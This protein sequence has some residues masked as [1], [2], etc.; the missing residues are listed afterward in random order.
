M[1]ICMG[2]FS[3]WL[4]H[5]DQ[6]ELF[7]YLY[8]NV[9]NV[10]FLALTALLLWPLGRAM[11]ALH[12]AKGY[13]LFWVVLHVAAAVPVLSRR[14]FRVDMGSHSGAH[15]IPGLAVSVFLQAGWSAFAALTVH[16]FVVGT[17]ARAAVALYLAGLVSSYVASAVVCA[18]YV[19]S[20]SRLVNLPLGV[21][22]FIVFSVWPAAG[23]AIYGRFFDLF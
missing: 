10:V 2:E 19:G 8:A 7:D 17:P 16:S 5:N 6:K 14:I 22:S 20:L 15:V 13:L 12:L 9:L 23:R 21:I 11:M 18:L 3:K 1:V 4:L